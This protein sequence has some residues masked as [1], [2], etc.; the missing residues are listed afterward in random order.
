MFFM[1]VLLWSFYLRIEDCFY[2]NFILK[3]I[4]LAWSLKI[5]IKD[6]LRKL[7]ELMCKVILNRKNSNING[8]FYAGDF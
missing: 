5:M 4:N 8:S 7:I 3:F 1:N 6:I 2:Y